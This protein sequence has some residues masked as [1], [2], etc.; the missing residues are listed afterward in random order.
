LNLVTSSKIAMALIVLTA[1]ALP[2]H[3]RGQSLTAIDDE[4]ETRAEVTL[5]TKCPA[6]HYLVVTAGPKHLL[7]RNEK[8]RGDTEVITIPDPGETRRTA[9]RGREDRR[10]L[11]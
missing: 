3:V 6:G 11:R 1:C 10:G 2:T 4:R 8:Q 5:D 7:I 9:D